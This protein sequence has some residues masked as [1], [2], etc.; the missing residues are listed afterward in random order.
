MYIHKKQ[1]LFKVLSELNMY[2]AHALI[3]SNEFRDHTIC[4]RML[5][6]TLSDNVYRLKMFYIYR[7]FM[8][9]REVSRSLVHL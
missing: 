2:I 7:Q 9:L 6:Y 5:F 8:F 4:E 3:K 1:R